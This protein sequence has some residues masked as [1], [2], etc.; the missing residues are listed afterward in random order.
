MNAGRAAETDAERA[1]SGRERNPRIAAYV[2][3]AVTIAVLVAAA[4]AVTHPLIADEIRPLLVLLVLGGLSAATLDYHNEGVGYSFTGFVLASSLPLTGPTGAALVGAVIPLFERSNR[5]TI[6][7]LFNTALMVLMGVFSGMA[8][9]WCRGLLPIPVHDTTPGQLLQHVGLPLLIADIV[10][11]VVNA[12]LLAGMVRLQGERFQDVLA[13]A[14]RQTAPLYLGYTVLAFLFVVLWRPGQLY[15]LSAV[16]IM[17]PLLIAR[18]AYTQYGEEFR[19]HSRILDTLI[20]AGDGWDRGGT[21]HGKRVGHY[22]HLMVDELGLSFN[23]RRDLRYASIL[24]DIGGLGVPRAILEKPIE[25]RDVGDRREIAA[26]P[27]MAAE[28]VGDI[29][30]LADAARAIRHHHE[31]P[32][33]RGYPDGLRAD[34]IP[35]VARL[36][37]VADAF[38]ALTSGAGSFPAL[39][40]DAAIQEL[41]R[42]AGTQ[43][44]PQCVEALARVAGRV[45]EI[46]AGVPEQ[47]GEGPWRDH[48]DPR[49][50]DILLTGRPPEQS[51]ALPD[52]VTG[53][54][55]PPGSP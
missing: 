23:E 55:P 18:W 8:Y 7:H 21:G 48:D 14:I 4:S 9:V 53:T 37:A 1:A 34:E 5:W 54:G 16:L 22:T 17:A 33:G 28:I 38:D 12:L 52:P 3:A 44:D 42:R 6:A 49:V 40:P 51:G 11:M 10:G 15:E 43:F 50:N 26:H 29:E 36:I 46:V 13:G 45:D 19:A 47:R 31:R 20:S 2:G 32:D 27:I 25:L 35:L 24:H 41:R 39:E 30:F